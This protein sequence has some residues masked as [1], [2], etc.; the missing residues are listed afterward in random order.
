MRR[1]DCHSVIFEDPAL[2]DFVAPMQDPVG[3]A[4]G[5]GAA[6]EQPDQAAKRMEELDPLGLQQAPEP[7][8]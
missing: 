7:C 5:I 3:Q 2:P 4:A 1:G 6:V 8:F